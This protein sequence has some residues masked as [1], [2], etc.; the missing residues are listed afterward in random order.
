M[1]L[2]DYIF[3]RITKAYFKWDGRSGATGIAGVTMVQ[4]FLLIDIF[5]FITKLLKVDNLT[6]YSK[7][8]TTVAAVLIL[9]LFAFNFYKYRESYNKLRFLWKNESESKSTV[10]GV[11]VVFSILFPII[12]LYIISNSL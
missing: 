2:F 5:F 11:F 4:S 10:G 3:Y 1:K 6:P 9:G 12:L 7:T 8:I